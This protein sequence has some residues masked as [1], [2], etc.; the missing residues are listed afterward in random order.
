MPYTPEDI[1]EYIKKV[2]SDDFRDGFATNSEMLAL[3]SRLDGSISSRSHDEI[4]SSYNLTAYAYALLDLG[5]RLREKNSNASEAIDAFR[6]A[7]SSLQSAIS[8]S[9]KEADE[10]KFDLVIAASSYHLAQLSACAYYQISSL[11]SS[12]KLTI[13]ERIL[14]NLIL[15]NVPEMRNVVFDYRLSGL[16]SD[17]T[18]SESIESWVPN[19]EK[20]GRYFEDDVLLE[21]IDMSL[22]NTYCA[23]MSAFLLGLERGE[24]YLIDKALLILKKGLKVCSEWNLVSQWW[25]FRITAHIVGDVWSN[26]YHVRLKAYAGNDDT[27]WS[28]LR[29]LFIA[30]LYRKYRAEIDLWPSQLDAAARSVNEDDDLVVSLPTSSGKTRIAELCILR[31]MSQRRRAIFVVPLRALATQTEETLRDTFGPLG[32]RVS[33]YYEGGEFGQL[34]R[35]VTY[36][37][38]ILVMTP[39]KLD[40]ATR[41]DKSILDD[42]GLLVFDE[43]HMIKLDERGVK[44]E[45]LIQRLLR[46]S[47]AGK[48][49][50][51]CLSAVFPSGV[52]IDDFSNWIRQDQAGRSVRETWQPTKLRFGE[53][54]WKR[55]NAEL[56]IRINER[57]CKTEKFISEVAL[58]IELSS[59]K[60][61]SNQREL[62]IATAWKIIKR[63]QTVLIYC[64]QKRDVEKFAS[65]IIEMYENG[66]LDPIPAP[67]TSDLE[68]A[69]VIAKE[70]FGEQSDI[71]RCLNIGIG[72][73]HAALPE[74]YLREIE[75]LIKN[76]V[77]T[78]VISSPTLAQ[79][80]NL[81][82]TS[83]VLYSIYRYDGRSMK[84]IDV[85]EF[86]N[87]VG[88]AGRAYIDSEG[89]VLHPMYTV[90]KSKMEHWNSRVKDSRK[91]R[92]ESCLVELV[93]YL[94]ERVNIMLG[95]EVIEDDYV[96]GNTYDWD[97]LGSIS[98]GRGNVEERD[99]WNKHVAMLDV[100]I[101]SLLGDS[102]TKVEELVVALD[103]VLS[104]SLWSKYF[105][106]N[107]HK[108]ESEYR[109][110]VS[111]RCQYIWKN[112]TEKQR[113]GYFLAGVGFESGRYLD[114]IEKLVIGSIGNFK[115]FVDVEEFDNAARS[116]VEIAELVFASPP[117]EPDKKPDNWNLILENWLL[118]KPPYGVGQA[119]DSDIVNFI[120]NGVVFKLAW[121]IE[122]IGDR[123]LRDIDIGDSARY[124]VEKRKFELAINSI[125]AGTLS[126]PASTLILSGFPIRSAAISVVDKLGANFTD[127]DGLIEWLNS[128]EILKK[129]DDVRWPTIAS[130]AI[131]KKFVSNVFSSDRAEWKRWE[132]TGNVKWNVD[133]PAGEVPL[134]IHH[135]DSSALV[136]SVEGDA[137]G[138]LQHRINKDRAGLTLVKSLSDGDKVSISYIGPNDFLG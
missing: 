33:S 83:I 72:L 96:L 91:Y 22:T 27:E 45:A 58:P 1:I 18:L 57:K 121:A 60:F 38:D 94:L 30:T 44:Y 48:R 65:A 54:I 104:L 50:I 10:K 113:K 101:L 122:V 59:K 23:S 137:L 55:P 100:M 135:R 43:G 89:V 69:I 51:V 17:E 31:C 76:R 126:V 82:I 130:H 118:G 131:W 15:R 132:W 8:I 90:T 108:D 85:S 123:A 5:L 133:R 115:K 6:S 36:K 66:V 103:E 80:I 95:R 77:I 28:R 52:G 46:R 24:S 19:A 107:R 128:E 86:H 42:V 87:V 35:V 75:K 11:L 78:V 40:F 112:S 114:G 53:V 25:I 39:E 125:T 73:H 2:T 47:D 98:R 134:Q 93:A 14:M 88:R 110:L 41:H 26:T 13:I 4:N 84:P 79:G 67:E 136:L 129:R 81:P 116:I 12:N 63:N 119:G 32:I 111:S 70:W 56:I 21:C 61:P 127:R 105:Q 109:S 117:F 49:R 124:V 106:N 138:V 34:D 74:L 37:N 3:I 92:L 120:E 29:E 68:Y 16:A 64:P 99:E 20:E 71:I 9:S 97:V 62:C 102:D 7:A